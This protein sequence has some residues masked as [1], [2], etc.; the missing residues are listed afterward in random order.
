MQ[1]LPEHGIASI[2]LS[3]IAMFG[4][5]SRM[6]GGGEST[7]ICLFRKTFEKF[8]PNPDNSEKGQLGRDREDNFC[9]LNLPNGVYALLRKIPCQDAAPVGP[10]GRSP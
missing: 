9:F 3:P 5:T 6:K 2:P 1:E 4:N 8:F 10:N 7:A